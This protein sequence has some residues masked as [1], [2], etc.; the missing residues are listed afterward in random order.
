MQAPR[1]NIRQKSTPSPSSWKQE[2]KQACLER[3]RAKKQEWNHHRRCHR[4]RRPRGSGGPS[5]SPPNAEARHVVQDF[6][7]AQGITVRNGG[8]VGNGIGASLPLGTTCVRTPPPQE[9]M[10]EMSLSVS[11][12][13]FPMTGAPLG[14]DFD[15]CLQEEEN[16]SHYLQEAELLE[17]MYQVQEELAN[18]E[19]EAHVQEWELEEDFGLEQLSIQIQE[20]DILQEEEQYCASTTRMYNDD[21]VLATLQ[22][23]NVSIPSVREAIVPCPICWRGSL[24][25][26]ASSKTLSC[27]NYRP[28]AQEDH[29]MEDETEQLAGDTLCSFCVLL[30]TV[31]PCME[32]GRNAILPWIKER[33]SQI[34]QE[35]SLY[36]MG[37][38]SFQVIPRHEGDSN[39]G[40]GAPP[41]ASSCLQSTCDTCSWKKLIHF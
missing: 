27:Q 41:A 6:L 29:A 1:L 7:V 30:Q 19:K 10:A 28:V 23:D 34:Y 35:H 15:A 17:L 20:F 32:N 31:P 40:N 16:D 11:P 13:A 4:D 9:A 18:E 8:T 38:L 5:S 36:C 2:F 3:A 39:D 25:Y 21:G 26:D 33:M 14:S 24:T 22:E 12:I 37:L